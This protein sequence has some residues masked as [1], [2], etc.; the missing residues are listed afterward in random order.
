MAGDERRIATE[1]HTRPPASS[2]RIV[3]SETAISAGWAFSVSVSVSAGPFQIVSLSRSPERR[4]DFVENLTRRRK[5]L[6]QSLAHADRLTALSR[7]DK[8]D[9]HKPPPQKS[10]KILRSQVVS[11]EASPVRN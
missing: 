9:R 10:R 4:I 6:G 8:R 2:T 5:G 1:I 3:A 11:S 7:K